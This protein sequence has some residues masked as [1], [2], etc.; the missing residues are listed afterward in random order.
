MWDLW[1]TVTRRRVVGCS[2]QWLWVSRLTSCDHGLAC[3]FRLCLCWLGP[4]GSYF[5]ACK[6][7]KLLL[8]VPCVPLRFVREFSFWFAASPADCVKKWV[9]QRARG[10]RNS[11]EEWVEWSCVSGTEWI[12]LL[13]RVLETRRGFAVNYR[14]LLQAQVGEPSSTTEPVSLLWID[15]IVSSK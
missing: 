6:S 14:R 8:F 13:D 11:C 2:S 5:L 9:R 3:T 4:V 15:E 1:L 10:E 7:R 12:D